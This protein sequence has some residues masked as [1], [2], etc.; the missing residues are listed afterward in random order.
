MG[1]SSF[2]NIKD[3]SGVMQFY[4][5]KKK[6]AEEKFK[7]FKQSDIGDV[8]YIKGHLFKTKTKELTIVVKKSKLIR[9]VTKEIIE[10]LNWGY[11]FFKV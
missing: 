2:A 8:I 7:I 3:E 1:N 10:K 4:V 5:D 11:N 9:I 6:L